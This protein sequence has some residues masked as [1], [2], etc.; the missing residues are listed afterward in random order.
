[1]SISPDFSLRQLQY[2]V[3]VADTLSF[4]K[5]AERCHVSQPSLSVQLLRLEEA[6][7][8]QLFERTRRRVL[9][10]PAG[11]VLVERARGILLDVEDF[12]AAA[13]RTS[14]PLRGTLRLGVIPTISPYLLPSA[15]PVLRA[16]F[17]QLRT[18]WLEDKTPVL[19][20]GLGAGT[21][22]A[23]LLALEADLG[24]VDHAVVG[25]DPFLLATRRDDPLGNRTEPAK[26]SELRARNVLLLD[27]GHCL[28]DQ[29]LSYCSKAKT[30]ELEFR[31]TSLSTLAHMVAGGAGVTL[32]PRIAVPTE[33]H[34]ANLCVREFVKPGPYRTIV[35]AWRQ[36]SPVGG[37]L[38]QVAETLRQCFPA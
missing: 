32:L 18:I 26:P 6:L 4:R 11:R 36:R 24:E 12:Q 8:V 15:T 2:A 3:A 17:P 30:R 13:R 31:A 27:D 21:I 5:A 37:A 35:L 29:V 20:R 23:A 38:K 25:V 14:D 7:G 28:R 34:G 10:T 33:A 9:L 22:D 1:M 16:T 19:V